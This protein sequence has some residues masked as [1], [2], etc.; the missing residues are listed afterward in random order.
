MRLKEMATSGPA[1]DEYKR[2]LAAAVGE[3]AASTIHALATCEITEIRPI[4]E[5]GQGGEQSI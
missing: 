1:F 4:L 2:G 5:I 3:K